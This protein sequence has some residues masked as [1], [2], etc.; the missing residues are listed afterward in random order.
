MQ[1]EDDTMSEERKERVKKLRR[2]IFIEESYNLH[3]K[4]PKKDPEM[5]DT[6][7]SIIKKFVDE[8]DSK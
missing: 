3:K 2:M 8:E 6:I 1:I 5:V 4:N 7:I